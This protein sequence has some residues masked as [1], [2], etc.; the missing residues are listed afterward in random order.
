MLCPPWR[1]QDAI[2]TPITRI[3]LTKLSEGFSR[4]SFQPEPGSTVQTGKIYVTMTSNQRTWNSKTQTSSLLKTKWQ[5]SERPRRTRKHSS[6]TTV[7]SYTHWEC[8]PTQREG[9]HRRSTNHHKRAADLPR[10]RWARYSI[11]LQTTKSRSRA[12]R[13]WSSSSSRPSAYSEANRECCLD[14]VLFKVWLGLRLWKTKRSYTTS[15]WWR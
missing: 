14:P 11:L 2:W 9:T 4:G 7:R 3:F 5:R 12:K 13:S 6:T 1:V 8:V 10:Q 15:K